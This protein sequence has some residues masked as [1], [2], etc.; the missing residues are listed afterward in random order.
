MSVIDLKN[1]K[2]YLLDEEDE[3]SP[4]EETEINDGFTDLI[5]I[6]M[7]PTAKVTIHGKKVSGKPSK[8]ESL[9]QAINESDP[10]KA[11]HKLAGLIKSADS[12][13]LRKQYHVSQFS[14]ENYRVYPI[15]GTSS[16]KELSVGIFS[17][18]TDDETTL[19]LLYGKLREN[20]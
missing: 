20:P 15:S 17:S 10:V 9:V 18:E 12:D 11:A 4:S 5:A 3:N 14:L 8:S 16:V 13:E 1:Y 19:H 7:D 6:K 2:Q